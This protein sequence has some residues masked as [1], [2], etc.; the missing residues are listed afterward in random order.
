ML[1]RSRARSNAADRMR[2][3]S[4]SQAR[5]ARRTSSSVAGCR[6]SS[7]RPS[8]S[9]NGTKDAGTTQTTGQTGP[10]G[11]T[12]ATRVQTG[13]DTYSSWASSLATN[14][15]KYI[16]S[17]WVKPGPTSDNVY[18]GT[19]GLNGSSY[20]VRENALLVPQQGV[21]R[22]PKGHTTAMVVGADGKAEVRPVRVSW[23]IDDKWLVEDGLAAGDKVIVEGLQKI[24][25][26]APVAAA[27]VGAPTPDAQ[28][29][30]QQ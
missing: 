26:G 20:G 7:V 23:A 16:P 10:D 17:A 30:P 25:P 12:G 21:A 27:Q 6:L 9:N 24:Q 8:A 14:A 15:V 18:Q 1:A 4:R 29:A 28:P 19:H 22:D 11:T 5:I 2:S 3:F 13:A